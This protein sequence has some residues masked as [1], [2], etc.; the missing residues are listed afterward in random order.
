MMT[1]T[2][3]CASTRISAAR[4]CGSLV[5]SNGRQ[6]ASWINRS[7]RAGRDPGSAPVQSITSKRKAESA[8]THCTNSSPSRAK[9]VRK[10]PWRAM[11]VRKALS[12]QV[13]LTEPAN[14]KA[15]GLL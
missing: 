4:N 9:V 7:R 8:T 14:W 15:I 13:A 5:R 11:R 12:S 3:A 2:D 6:A 1:K 10:V